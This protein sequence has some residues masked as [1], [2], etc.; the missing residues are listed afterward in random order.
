LIKDGERSGTRMPQS[1][2]R[3]CLGKFID[4]R[5]VGD[6]GCN[7]AAGSFFLQNLLRSKYFGLFLCFA[8]IHG[9]PGFAQVDGEIETFDL[10]MPNVLPKKVSSIQ[11]YLSDFDS[12]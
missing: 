4:R 1:R 5:N 8:L 12:T 10:L 6:S 2:R 3:S 11:M 9:Q 7:M